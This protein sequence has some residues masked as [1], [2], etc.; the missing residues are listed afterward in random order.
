M[1]APRLKILS[2]RSIELLK[3]LQISIYYAWVKS[4]G[5]KSF[6]VEYNVNFFPFLPGQA[7]FM[8]NEILK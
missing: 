2:S 8:K 6:S 7:I 5:Y 3:F 4:N 1:D